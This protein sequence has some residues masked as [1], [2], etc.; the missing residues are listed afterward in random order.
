MTLSKQQE[1]IFKGLD[2]EYEI[3]SKL[4]NIKSPMDDSDFIECLR[5]IRRTGFLERS[6]ATDFFLQN[7]DYFDNWDAFVKVRDLLIDD[8]QRSDYDWIISGIVDNLIEEA[9][10]RLLEAA[11][12]HYPYPR[13]SDSKIYGLLQAF[14]LR[15][16]ELM[17]KETAIKDLKN[18]QDYVDRNFCLIRGALSLSL[19]VGKNPGE[20]KKD[21]EESIG[22]MARKPFAL[23][24]KMISIAGGHRDRLTARQKSVLKSIITGT[25]VG[26]TSATSEMK[27]A[28]RA[29]GLISA[30]KHKHDDPIV[31]DENSKEF[32]YDTYRLNEIDEGRN[33]PRSRR[34][35]RRRFERLRRLKKRRP[36]L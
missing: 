32:L 15:L 3:I 18:C 6:K 21:L 17:D 36:P 20:M 9:Y 23:T 31:F 16:D 10:E 5:L 28:L 26:Q 29:L 1:G 19:L 13:R 22:K 25:K 7:P 4:L 11:D 34:S 12:R 30:R 14:R 2:K 33:R 8:D 24:L 35:S 27:E